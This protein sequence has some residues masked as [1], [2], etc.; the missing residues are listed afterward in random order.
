MPKYAFYAGEGGGEFDFSPDDKYLLSAGPRGSVFVWNLENG[1]KVAELPS[2]RR[3]TVKKGHSGP[4]ISLSK[5][6]SSGNRVAKKKPKPR[7]PVER[8]TRKGRMS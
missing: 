5:S 4:M 8:I 7:M 3:N 6:C 1:K 2:A